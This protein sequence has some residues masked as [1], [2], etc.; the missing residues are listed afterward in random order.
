MLVK[1]DPKRFV[2]EAIAFAVYDGK[3]A[4]LAAYLFRP[5]FR[6]AGAMNCPGSPEFPR[7]SLVVCSPHRARGS[8]HPAF[9]FALA[10]L[11][12]QNQAVWSCWLNVDPDKLK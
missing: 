5:L 6:P 9:V 2:G 4:L 1:D 12:I 10:T 11:S 8:Q 3:F 7:L